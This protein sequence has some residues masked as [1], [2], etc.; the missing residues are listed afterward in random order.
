MNQMGQ[1]DAPLVMSS[2]RQHFIMGKFNK[3]ILIMLM[4]FLIFCFGD[5]Y[6]MQKEKC[7]EEISGIK[8]CI[9]LK[10]Q[11]IKLNKG[12]EIELVFKNISKNPIRIYWIETEFFRSFQS[13]F[14]LL[15]DGK[16][17]FLTDISPPHGYVVSEDDFHLIDPNKEI[18][19]KQ[20]LSID[21]PKIESSLNKTQLKWTYENNI[22]KWEGGKMTVDGPTKKL[23]NGDKIPYIWIGKIDS[24]IEIE[25]I[26]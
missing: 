13:Y 23:F 22:S 1:K 25:I 19:F 16:F 6:A 11:N 8:T 4:H 18:I 3:L 10:H 5:I 15:A 26:K 12:F 2:V 7:S 20:T 24:I 9:R 14:Y 21:K 17:N